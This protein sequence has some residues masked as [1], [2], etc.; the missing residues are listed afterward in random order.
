MRNATFDYVGLGYVG[1]G[2]PD[3]AAWR[4]FGTR[5]CGL[6]PAR[7]LPG[8]QAGPRL[9]DEAAEG[10]AADGTVYLK[11]DD[12]QW[13]LAVHAR[14]SSSLEYLGFELRDEG[15]FERTCEVLTK[16]GAALREGEASEAEARSVGRLAVLEDPA[17]HRVELFSTPV[18]DRDFVSEGGTQFLTGELGMGHVVLYVPDIHAALDFYRNT[19]GFVRSDFLR[20]GPDDLGIHF[21]RCTRRHHSVALLHLGALSGLQHL[22]LETTSLDDVGRAL[23]RALG[24]AVPITSGLGRHRNDETVSFYMQSPSGFDVEIGWD[25]LLVGDDWVENEF[26]GGGDLWGHHG[27]DA[28]TLAPP[29]DA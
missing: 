18:R 29:E 4:L 28:D 23:D 27:L 1:I 26:A 16:R 8:G 19:L 7:I 25:G 2:A 17:G 20:F 3:P 22:M 13:R 9:V 12:R 24:D 15:E 14:E 11:M 10:V 21:L 6:A 5:I